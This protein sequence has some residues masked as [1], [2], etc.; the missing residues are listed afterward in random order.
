MDI[1]QEFGFEQAN[2]T[3]LVFLH[4]LQVTFFD[5][6]IKHGRHELVIVLLPTFLRNSISI[7]ILIV[8]DDFEI[9]FKGLAEFKLLCRVDENRLILWFR[10]LL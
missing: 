10:L 9:Y 3:F 6:L 7:A 5:R 2:Q 8:I 1:L 4:D